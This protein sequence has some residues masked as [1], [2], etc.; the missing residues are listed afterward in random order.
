DTFNIS[1]DGGYHF[2]SPKPPG[3][4]IM[5]FPYKYEINQGP[6]GYSVDT[7][8]VKVGEWYYAIA[9]GWPWPPNCDAGNA[10]HPCL[11]PGGAAPIRTANILDPT[12]WRGWS[13]KDFT[14]RFTDPYRASGVR[15]QDHMYAP[16]E[17]LYYVNALNIHQ[18]SQMLIATLWDPW[19]SAYGPPGLYF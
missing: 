7:N 18:P 4:L 14:V 12:G 6:E 10:A 5:G 15:P 3:N 11:V 19:D 17:Y 8:I 2:T 1:S 13:G 9:T 16:V